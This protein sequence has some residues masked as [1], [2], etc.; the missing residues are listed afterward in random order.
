MHMYFNI[1]ERMCLT[2]GVFVLFSVTRNQPARE[3]TNDDEE[4]QELG[5]ACM[6]GMWGRFNGGSA[7]GLKS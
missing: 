2:F 7:C 4:E 1:I 5:M 3:Q 6:G